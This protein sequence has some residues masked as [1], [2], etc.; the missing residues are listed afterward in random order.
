MGFFSNLFKPKAPAEHPFPDLF[1]LEVE[2]ERA[3]K[4]GKQKIDFKVEELSQEKWDY[5]SG[6]YRQLSIPITHPFNHSHGLYKRRFESVK[7]DILAGRQISLDEIDEEHLTAFA[8]QQLP[9]IK[10]FAVRPSIIKCVIAG[11]RFHGYKNKIIKEMLVMDSYQKLVLEPE[12]DNKF[13][14]DAVKLMWE[15]QLLGYVPREYS[16]EV[17]KAI[18]EMKEVKCWLDSYTSIG[19]IDE[20]AYVE[21]ALDHAKSPRY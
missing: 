20:R 7:E 17:A 9:G 18:E 19:P 12:P 15:G 4:G 8:A 2:I 3:L 11:F 6:K 1:P 16:R 10:I 5:L 21:I 14:I 13:D